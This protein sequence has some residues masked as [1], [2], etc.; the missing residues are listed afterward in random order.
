MVSLQ[1]EDLWR[2]H[3]TRFITFP[4][5]CKD[6]NSEASLVMQKISKN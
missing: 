1:S 6:Q 2:A 4:N 5:A 3:D